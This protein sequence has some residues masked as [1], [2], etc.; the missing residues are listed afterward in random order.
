M[1]RALQR[2]ERDLEAARARLADLDEALDAQ[3]AALPRTP[4]SSRDR[5]LVVEALLQ[6]ADLRQ[7]W[8]LRVRDAERARELAQWEVDHGQPFGAPLDADAVREDVAAM[9]RRLGMTDDEREAEGSKR[10]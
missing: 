5:G 3:A 7:T 6:R 2:A 4:P 9:R 1:T 8:A 10:R